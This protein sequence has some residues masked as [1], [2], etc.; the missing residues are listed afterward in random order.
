MQARGRLDEAIACYQEAARLEPNYVD[1]RLNLA[2]VLR[3]AGRLSES[4]GR[5]REIAQ[6]HPE[7]AENHGNLGFALLL[8][9]QLDEGWREYEWRLK[10]KGR[11]GRDANPDQPRWEGEPLEGRTILLKAEQGM[12]DSIQFI[13]YASLAAQKGG[14]VLVECPAA[15]K[16]LIAS[17]EGVHAVFAT[18]EVLPDFDVFAPLPSLPMLF[19]TGLMDIPSKVPYLLSG[20]RREADA[21][22]HVGLAWA[23][24]PQHKNDRHRSVPFRLLDALFTV[25]GVAWH[26]LQCG[27]RAGEWQLAGGKSTNDSIAFT[28]FHDTA[29]AVRRLD[30]VIAVDTAVAHLA[31]ALGADVWVMLP[32]APDWRWMLQRADSP[33]YPTMKLFRQPAPGDWKTVLAQIAEE[34]RV[35]TASAR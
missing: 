23:G 27:D 34:L 15:L 12:G 26:N 20:A 17:V 16:R 28:D 31:G 24:N 10:T 13:R 19:K 29:V 30:L 3:E 8:D 9:G 5:H 21:D 4:I 33:W 1:A 22:F 35:K 14:R 25:E 6:T 32:F 7:L 2:T 11:L 18:G